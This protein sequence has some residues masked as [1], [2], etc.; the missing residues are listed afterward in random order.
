MGGPPLPPSANRKDRLYRGYDQD[1]YGGE[2]QEKL[3]WKEEPATTTTRRRP[4]ADSKK[5]RHQQQQQQ[6]SGSKQHNTNLSCFLPTDV[7]GVVRE[8]VAMVKYSQDPYLDFRHSMAE[9]I[10]EKDIHQPADLEELL[11]CYLTL[12]SPRQYHLIK[13]AFFDTWNEL[14]SR[15]SRSFWGAV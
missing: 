1:D 12:N 14:L 5:L 11:H 7:S 3:F 13:K 2:A 9:M 10:L 6:R 15:R 8:S 4:G